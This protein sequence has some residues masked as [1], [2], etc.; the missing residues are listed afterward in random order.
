[1]YIRQRGVTIAASA[2]DRPN[3]FS[4]GVPHSFRTRR[5]TPPA[6]RSDCLSTSRALHPLPTALGW[7]VI[8]SAMG[9]TTNGDTEGN[10]LPFAREINFN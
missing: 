10:Y 4:L 5:S 7:A 2:G 6:W 8:E 1:M 3:F 9:V